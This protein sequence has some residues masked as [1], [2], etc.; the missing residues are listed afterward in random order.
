M[1]EPEMVR[2]LVFRVW[3]DV[4]AGRTAEHHKVELK[5]EWWDFGNRQGKEEFAKDLAMMANTPGG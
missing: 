4:Q 1:V 3:Q 2:Q 5:R